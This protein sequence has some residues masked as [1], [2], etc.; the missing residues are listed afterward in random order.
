MGGRQWG[1]RSASPGVRRTSHRGPRT[2][3]TSSWTPWTSW[4]FEGQG[5]GMT[6]EQLLERIESN[7]RVMA[8]QPVIKGTRLTVAYIRRR[9]AQGSTAGD[10]LREHEGLVADDIL[11]CLLYPTAG[12]SA[13]GITQPGAFDLGHQ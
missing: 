7:P 10:L 8:G 13:A 6:N 4:I 1:W 9:V 11:A 3:W 2:N 5:R 12:P